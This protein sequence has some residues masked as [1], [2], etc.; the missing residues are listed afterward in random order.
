MFLIY[1]CS[2]YFETAVQNKRD[3]NSFAQ[4]DG[5]ISVG[6]KVNRSTSS[7]AYV[8]AIKDDSTVTLSLLPFGVEKY[9]ITRKRKGLAVQARAFNVQLPDA[10]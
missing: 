7:E 4:L 10:F 9:Q 5:G 6:E 2:K 8:A 1:S 3:Y